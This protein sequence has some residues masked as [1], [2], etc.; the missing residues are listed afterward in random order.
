MTTDGSIDPDAYLARIGADRPRGTTLADLAALHA[1]HP[2]A[3]PFEDYD[4]HLGV[5]LSLDTDRLFDKVVTRGRGGFCYELNGLFAVLLRELGFDV[6]LCSAFDVGPDGGHGPDFEHLRLLV[7][8]D[9][10]PYLADVGN[11]ASWTAPVPLEPGTHGDTQVHRDGEL[12]WA[13]RRTHQGH[14]EREWAWTLRPRELAEFLPRCRYQENDP[15]SHFVNRRLAALATEHGRISVVNGVL[16]E[17]EGDRQTERT[18]D[19]DEERAVLVDRFGIDLGGREWKT[20]P[21]L[22]P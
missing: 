13:F 21:P 9:D 19:P 15:H 17:T 20:G 18:L 4:I 12:W 3:V 7:R 5:P 2:R 1:A 6:T 16:K 22:T 8:T 10:G 11:G 14:W